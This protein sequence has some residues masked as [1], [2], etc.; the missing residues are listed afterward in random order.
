MWAWN[1]DVTRFAA[2]LGTLGEGLSGC[3][4]DYRTTD[5]ANAD[6]IYAAGSR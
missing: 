6:H 1:D 4:R 5:Q 2:Y 3:A